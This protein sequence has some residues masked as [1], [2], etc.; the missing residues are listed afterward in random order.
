MHRLYLLIQPETYYGLNFRLGVQFSIG[1]S[2][3]LDNA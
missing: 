3:P 2:D 1:P